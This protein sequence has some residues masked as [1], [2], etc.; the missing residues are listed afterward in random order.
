MIFDFYE[1]EK[2]RDPELRWEDITLFKL[3]L[4]SAYTLLFFRPDVVRLVG[5]LMT[6]GLALF[7]LCGVFGWCGTPFAFQV[8]TRALV[9]E[10]C[11]R[12]RGDAK[13]FVDDLLGVT[14]KRHVNSDVSIAIAI[15]RALLGP[16]AVAMEKLAIGR[17]MDIIG[18]ILNLDLCRVSV[19]RRNI[20]KAI[21]GFFTISQ[22]C[23]QLDLQRLASWSTRYGEV[24]RWMR[25]QSSR[26][27]AASSGEWWPSQ[28]AAR[29]AIPAGALTAIQLWRAMLCLGVAHP[30]HFCRSMLSYAYPRARFVV[31]FDASLFGVGL[32]WWRR[33]DDGGETLLGGASLSLADLAFGEDSKHQ[34][35][36]EYIAVTLGIAGLATFFGAR[37]E[38]IDLRG[39]SVTA[40]EWAS[41]DRSRSVIAWNASTVQVAVCSAA[42]IW[43]NEVF[44]I[45]GDDN[46]IC[47]S[48]SRGALPSDLDLPEGTAIWRL[49]EE[50]NFRALVGL[51]DPRLASDQASQ[52]L[53]LWTAAW[54][55]TTAL[56]AR[57]QP[58]SAN[59]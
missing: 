22:R 9:H 49:D 45:A 3:D 5:F 46:V 23:T 42:E 29:I 58:P 31:H 55:T 8:V 7:L 47:D 30:Q 27:Y 57:Q 15:C 19:T 50:E 35:T 38:A 44:H 56:L 21:H 2:R 26:L 32:L 18:W 53:P 12:I 36:A 41:R 52:F 17:I 28:P 13:M 40:L 33:A 16:D 11:A 39:D 51:C 48:L 14:T 37:D 10:I 34:N 25:P 59:I 24:H 43:V 4:K 6:H 54:K 20:L 1:T